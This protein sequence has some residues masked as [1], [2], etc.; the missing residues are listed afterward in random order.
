MSNLKK[1]GIEERALLDA[2]LVTAYFNVV[3]RIVTGLGVEL[4]TDG[5][6][7]YDYD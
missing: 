1:Q 3:N 5:G 4:E 2:N 7:G 6:K